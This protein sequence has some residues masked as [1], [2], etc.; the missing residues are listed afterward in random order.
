[1]TDVYRALA[2]LAAHPRI[3]GQRVALMGFSFGGRTALWASHPRFRERYA[4]G[5]LRFAAHIAVYPASCY[6]RLADEGSIADVP[7]RILHGTDDDWT[8]I[9]ACRDYAARLRGLGK[10]IVLVEYAGA[11]HSFDS[12][13]VPARW[14]I[15]DVM[16]PGGCVF[17]ERDGRLLDAAG[18]EARIDSPCVVRGGSVGQNPAARQQATADVLAFLGGVF[19]MR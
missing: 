19:G 5:P 14:E 1:M 6:I 3:D 11:A 18:D 13:A 10:D 2:V 16:N 8:P 12:P 4:A 9:A 7:I 17:T 15:P